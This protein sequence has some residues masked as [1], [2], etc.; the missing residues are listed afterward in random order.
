VL[1]EVYS[2]AFDRG[3][4]V[5]ALL[6]YL[7]ESPGTLLLAGILADFL[8]LGSIVRRRILIKVVGAFAIYLVEEVVSRLSI[9][10]YLFLFF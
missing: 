3:F 1:R 6:N 5:F 8:L 9:V 10:S 2:A 4:F 7:G